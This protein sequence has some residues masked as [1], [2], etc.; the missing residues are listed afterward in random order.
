MIHKMLKY[1]K[2][3]L[4]SASPRRQSIFNMLGINALQMPANID[5]DLFSNNPRKLVK[6]HAENKAL[7][8]R[9][10]VENDYLIVG[11]D[12]IVFQKPDIL[13]KPQSKYQAAE[14]LT[15]LSGIYHDVYTGVAISYKNQIISGIE[16]TRVTF[17]E[18]TPQEIEEYIK[19]NEPMDKAGAYGIQGYGSQFVSKISGCY[20]NV[21][22]FPVNCFYKLLKEI[23]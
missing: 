1:K 17:C 11:S 18:L 22:G 8:V 23:L 21:M 9:K 19:T 12:T 6:T 7:A 16:K 5:E 14:Y 2:V 3:I 15:R 10:T 20:F 13:E 4:A